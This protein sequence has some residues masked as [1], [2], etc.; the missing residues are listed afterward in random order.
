MKPCYG[1][2]EEGGLNGGIYRWHRTDEAVVDILSLVAPWK[3]DLYVVI[4]GDAA[5]GRLDNSVL[6]VPAQ[7]AED[8]ALDLKDAGWREATA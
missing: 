8:A 3:D 5:I 6:Q 1:R 4:P 2:L 7:D